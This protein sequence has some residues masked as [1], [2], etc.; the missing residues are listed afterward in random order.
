MPLFIMVIAHCYAAPNH[1]EMLEI[2]EADVCYDCF[3]QPTI[4][5]AHGL[6][7][8]WLNKRVILVQLHR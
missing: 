7:I 8:L 4:Y 5:I 3:K 2:L 6:S 1:F